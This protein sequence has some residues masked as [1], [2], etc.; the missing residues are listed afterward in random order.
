MFFERNS[1][2]PLTGNS[3]RERLQQRVI[4]A[5]RSAM[6]TDPS[7]R[8]TIIGSAAA[9]EPSVL[10]RER[11]AWAIRNLGVDVSRISVK[12]ENPP[13]PEEL[14]LLDEQRSVTFLINDR[15][16][17]LFAGES[18]TFATRTPAS[19]S[20]AHILTC[21]TTCQE[22][23][24][25]TLNGKPLL[26]EGKGPTYRVTIDTSM[27]AEDGGMLE[28]RS[29]VSAGETA[30]R[31]ARVLVLMPS[32][33]EK[34]IDVTTM[35]DRQGQDVRTLSYF[36]FNSSAP[37]MVDQGSLEAVR[38]AL[39]SGASVTLIASTDNIGTEESNRLLAQKRA[40]AVMN[41]LGRSERVT[42]RIDVTADDANGSPMDRVFNRSVRAQI[43]P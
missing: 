15:P 9:D 2:A 21:D 39:R 42:I 30:S 17:L 24:T 28:I 18:T 26:V 31:D 19:I 38:T 22:S 13:Q 20:F 43:V 6:V 11:Y 33:A 7:L 35:D 3:E 36:D 27:I 34:T 4:D 12:T 1:T 25:A 23:V 41:M 5:V 8:L 14:A 29:S 32:T 10:A 37:K 40:Q 16:A